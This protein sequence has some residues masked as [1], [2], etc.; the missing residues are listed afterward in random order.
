MFSDQL[1]LMAMA[2]SFFSFVSGGAMLGGEVAVFR[3][4]L[5][6]APPH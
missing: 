2:V 5:T 4:F 1:T 3:V 6:P